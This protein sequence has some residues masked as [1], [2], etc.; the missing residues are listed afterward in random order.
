MHKC[1]HTRNN[2][3]HAVAERGG[4]CVY[5]CVWKGFIRLNVCVGTCVRVCVCVCVLHL[6][7][8]G[9][10]RRKRRRTTFPWDKRCSCPLTSCY[11]YMY[12]YWPLNELLYTCVNE[13]QLSLNELRHSCLGLFSYIYEVLFMNIRLFCWSSTNCNSSRDNLNPHSPPWG[14]FPF[15]LGSR[16]RATRKRNPPEKPAQFCSKNW[17]FFQGGPLLLGFSFGNHPKRKSPRGGGDSFS[18]TAPQLVEDQKESPVFSWKKTSIYMERDLKKSREMDSLSLWDGLIEFVRWTHWVREMDS[19][20]S[21]I[22]SLIS[23]DKTHWVREMDTLTSWDR[24]IEF[25]R[26]YI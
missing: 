14:R 15:W 2:T 13:V 19:L 18:Q 21:E 12:V 9:W 8:I 10:E 3:C 1:C 24:L 25:V 5:G 6:T 4:W 20:S 16:W 7:R 17:G 11:V 22:D 26:I 23:W